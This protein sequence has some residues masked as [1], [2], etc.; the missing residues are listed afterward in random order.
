MVVGPR[1]PTW[2]DIDILTCAAECFIAVPEIANDA[3]F[4][5]VVEVSATDGV[6]AVANVVAGPATIVV[7]VGVIIEP[8]GLVPFAIPPDALAWSPVVV[9]DVANGINSVVNP[10]VFNPDV[11]LPPS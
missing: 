9:Q 4:I 1:L 6:G 11:L 3:V 2:Y 5:A 7:V 8:P 10:V